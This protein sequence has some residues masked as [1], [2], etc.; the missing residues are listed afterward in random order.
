MEV[1]ADD[2]IAFVRAREK[3]VDPVL[4]EVRPGVSVVSFI[5]NRWTVTYEFTEI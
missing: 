4:E 5:R 2:L 3:D 1:E